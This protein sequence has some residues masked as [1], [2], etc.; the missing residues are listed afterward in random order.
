MLTVIG[1]LISIPVPFTSIR[2]TFQTLFVA[3]SGLVLG[4]RD[5]MYAQ[6]AYMLIGLI[7][8]PVF[9]TGGGIDYVL[10]PSFG[11][12]LGFPLQAFIT[13]MLKGKQKTLSTAKLFL[14]AL[15]G[16]LAAYAI[17]I[18]YQVVMVAYYIGNGLMAALAGVPSVLL[19]LV[20][21]AV[22]LYL[23][24]LLYPRIMTMIGKRDEQAAPLDTLDTPPVV[25]PAPE[26]EPPKKGKEKEKP[27]APVP[28]P[29]G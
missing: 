9:S 15:A 14:S 8:L 21:D 27:Q 29:A 13:G 16:M 19:M 12:I 5:G 1:G 20:K 24:C 7:G 4:A 11:Y 22:L 10:R 26:P 23:I 18:T 3:V 28:E 2:L 25:P 6:L 17:G